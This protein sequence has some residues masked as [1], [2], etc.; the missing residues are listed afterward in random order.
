MSR[1]RW[2]LLIGLSLAV[3]I[4]ASIWVQVPGYMDADYYFAT[5]R[6]LA[7]GRGFNQ[8]FLWN[9]LDEPEGLPH[10]SHSYWMPLASLVAAGAMRVM[11]ISFRIAQIPFVL[12]SAMLPL[13][14]AC[15]AL[16]LGLDQ[17]GVWL[18]ALLACAPGFYL[19]YFVTTE[20]FSLFAVVGGLALWRMAAAADRPSTP[21]WLLAGSL[22]G[23]AHLIRAD[24]FVLLV[25]AMLAV[26]YAGRKRLAGTAFMLFG[27]LLVMTPWWWR[28]VSTFGSPFPPGAGHALWLANYDD[29]F[30]YPASV[31]SPQNWMNT[32]LGS[33]LSTRLQ[34]LGTNLQSALAVNG[35]IFLAP[36][37]IIGM[38]RG[39]KR[40]LVRL[41]VVYF[42][43]LLVL[44]SFVLPQVGSRGGFF[45]SS[46]ALMPAFWA[47]AADGLDWAVSWFGRKRKWDL[48]QAQRFFRISAVLFA[49]LITVA[50]YWGRVIGEDVSQPSWG[51]SDA[52]YREVGQHLRDLDPEEGVVAVNNPP[53]FHVA[54]DFP[55]LAIPSSPPDILRQVV[56]RYEAKWVVLEENHPQALDGLYSQSLVLPWLRF[57]DEIRSDE[58]AAIL[59]FRVLADEVQP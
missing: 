57:A 46:A 27:Y 19:P 48:D 36:L 47:L 38:I 53:G 44:M 45:H 10:P 59:I 25:P 29:L 1:W 12:L 16:H 34:A 55:A 40:L 41:S 22:A 2:L 35:L 11:G 24:G 26:W 18:A 17:R 28:N 42:G 20:T 3:P 21:N 4:L 50:V 5:G 14:A 9:Y 56:N 52:I 37:M 15:Y 54:T 23:L 33:L 49:I 6:E 30:A 32:G 58:R 13:L 31:I 7:A 39:W 43:L 8:P 51:S